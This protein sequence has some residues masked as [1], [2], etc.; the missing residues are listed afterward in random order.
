MAL[1]DIT[2][3]TSRD[4]RI[5]PMTDRQA[6]DLVVSGSLEMGAHRPKDARAIADL[7]PQ[8]TPVFVNHL[9]RHTL[10]QSLDAL[11]ALR[12][13]GLE[14]VPHLA[15]RRITTRDEVVSFLRRAA[16]DAGVKKVLLIG[17]DRPEVSGPYYDG[18][19][20]LTDKVL[21]DGGIR[22]V[23]LP[24]YPEGH[25]VLATPILDKALAAKL[26]AA[27]AQ[28]LGASIV[29]QFSFHPA[30][31]IEHVTMLDRV[32][33]GIPVYVGLAG[34]T[35]AIALM[36]F[37]QQCGVSASLRALSREGMRAV[38]LVT[39]TDP[40]EQLVALARHVAAQRQSNVVGVHL[41][42][43]GGVGPTAAW[44]NA[45]VRKGAGR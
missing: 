45:V 21:I 30:R 13:A 11:V 4:T 42:T 35:S 29:T 33:V 9:P 6:A 24:S 19:S 18:L 7:L 44:M 23:A 36:R 1:T 8:G 5:S 38:N 34:P 43:F 26:A 2:R 12:D 37:A 15:A 16:G 32:H 25:P 28:G 17:G 22:E 10:A 14:P 41:F 27:K 39:H 31:I 40:S 3:D 20:V